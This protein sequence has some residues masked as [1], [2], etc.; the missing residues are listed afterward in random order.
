MR[1]KLLDWMG[2]LYL[3]VWKAEAWDVSHYKADGETLT[4]RC[5]EIYRLSVLDINT[6][7]QTLKSSLFAPQSFLNMFPWTNSSSFFFCLLFSML[8]CL[9]A[10]AWSSHFLRVQLPSNCNYSTES[11]A[12][13]NTACIFHISIKFSPW[14]CSTFI[15][16]ADNKMLTCQFS[17]R[18]FGAAIFLTSVLNMFIPSA[19]RVHYGCVMFVRILQ[20]LVEVSE[21]MLVA[22]K[23][24]QPWLYIYFDILR[25]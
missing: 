11:V 10:C 9:P 4:A 24:W 5:L 8:N 23:E 20:G 25:K 12:F 18:V 19:A 3:G 13:Y 14:K 16:K 1:H 2:C 21:N 17:H 6:S 7:A 15:S 22:S